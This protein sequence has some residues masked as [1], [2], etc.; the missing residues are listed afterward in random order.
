MSRAI[1]Y[2]YDLLHDDKATKRRRKHIALKREVLVNRLQ[3]LRRDIAEGGRRSRI[4]RDFA[5]F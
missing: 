2:A 4:D 5:K 1:A 3:K